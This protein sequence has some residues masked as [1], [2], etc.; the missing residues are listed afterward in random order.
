MDQM[1]LKQNNYTFETYNIWQNS[2]VQF[3]RQFYV[4]RPMLGAVATKVNK[5]PFPPLHS[6]LAGDITQIQTTV[7]QSGEGKGK[8]LSKGII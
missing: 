2:S 1:S 4:E 5:M 7:L 3:N 6:S 8:G